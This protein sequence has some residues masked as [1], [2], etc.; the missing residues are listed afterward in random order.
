MKAGLFV[1][2]VLGALIFFSLI[3]I[4]AGRLDYW[5]GWWYTIIG[6]AMLVV[7]MTILK[8]DTDLLL[9]R[10]KPGAGAKSF[11]KVILGL[12]FLATLAMFIVAGLD[13][14]RYYWSPAAGPLL[15]PIG[16]VLTVAGQILFLVAQKQN[17]FFSSVVR[18]QTERG[19]Q[20]CDTGLYSFVRHPAYMG[21]FIQSLGFPL[22]FGSLWA[23]IPVLAQ[24]VLLLVR[25]KLED[26]TLQAELPGYREYASRTSYRLVPYIW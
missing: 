20:V 17:R 5:P 25:T 24:I 4:S 11:D 19:H 16:T 26:K 10:S 21:T 2:Q 8:P 14:G 22:M 6:V 9:E 1:K 7:S 15:F 18:I 13:T 23:S 3:F 12:S